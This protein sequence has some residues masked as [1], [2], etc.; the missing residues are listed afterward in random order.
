MKTKAPMKAPPVLPAFSFK[1]AR[2][3]IL[4]LSLIES[5]FLFT[6]TSAA[7]EVNSQELA[8]FNLM[9]ATAGQ[10]RASV[11]LDPI[12][13]KVA[14]A[15]A[16]DMAARGYFA[17]VD[18]NGRGA[19]YLVRQ[20]GYTLPAGYSTAMSGN[21][22][23]SISAGR[24][25]ASQTW[26]DWMSS[27]PHRQHLLGEAGFFA[28][29]TSVGVGYVNVP[30]SE[31]T[32][33][34]VVIT[35]PPSGPQ[36]VITAPKGGSEVNDPFVTV[37]GTTGGEP[38]ATS[39]QVRVENASGE[40]AWVT[41]N[42]VA[43][44]TANVDGLVAGPNALR[45]QSLDGSG[46]VLR[47][48]VRN[49]RY[50][51]LAPVTIN[52][53]GEGS[54]TKGFTGTTMRE[55]SRSYTVT[56]T[57]KAGAIFA[58]WTG[59]VT[60]LAR[61]ITFTVPEGGL[62]IDASFI[63]N[64]FT[65]GVG[66]YA[67]LFTGTDGTHGALSLSLGNNGTFTAR[68]RLE[69]GA[70]ALK[71]RFDAAGAAQVTATDKTGA[72]YTLALTYTNRDGVIAIGGTI[73]GDGWNADLTLDS[74][75]KPT[76]TKHPKAGRYTLVVA[77]PEGA[78]SAPVGD[79]VATVRVSNTGAATITGALADGTPFNA[80]GTLTNDSELQIFTPLYTGTGV[81]T[82]T[83]NFRT[84]PT[85]DI[86]G[87]LH[88]SRPAKSGAAFATGFDVT[89]NAV[90]STYT[91]PAANQPIVPV[92]AGEN[93]SAL[94][95]GDGGLTTPV[96]QPTTLSTSNTLTISAPAVS[97]I[98]ATINTERGNFS[99]KFVHP[100]TGA[101]TSFRGVILQKQ[102]AGFGFFAND[103]D[104]GYATFAPAQTQAAL[105]AE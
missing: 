88:W 100:Q 9:K 59:G 76:A 75:G 78:T 74:L 22:I 45:V 105:I 46:A 56:A 72:T 55:V 94:A 73:S 16:A 44:W 80:R 34:W 35:A 93:N 58:G 92:N 15:R 27:A 26:N 52:V 63:A 19:N 81:L 20:A 54:I 41:A 62:T 18:P 4:I 5:G 31:W 51:V 29:Q 1:A 38:A 3:L 65:A 95:L 57:A 103:S 64:P 48:T 89:I 66:S 60:T 70:V 97:G 28:E 53:S 86:D 83:L 24:S 42:G 11:E 43:T 102:G 85:S 71:G 37:S 50:V 40:G 14:H 30:G 82:G 67:S 84:R 91:T 61:T 47:E 39:V 32:W 69:N 8:I 2:V 77:A 21:N 96:V 87:A 7:V 33:Y 6:P 36:L 98:R 99:G 49:I 23:E 101:V 25:S 13:C 12:L 17:H 10:R 90:G 79:G 104:A 68:L